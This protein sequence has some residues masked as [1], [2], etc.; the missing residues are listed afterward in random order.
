MRP[1]ILFPLFKPVTSLAGVGPRLGK[2]I[3]GLAGPHLADL[4]WHL[5]SGLIDRRFAPSVADTLPGVIATLTV[6]VDQHLKP[7]RPKL[8]YKVLCSDATGSLTL[9][10]FHAHEDYLRRQLPEGE[11][12]IISGRIEHF[13][14]EIQMA[15]PDYIARPEEA[16]S[17]R[18]VEPVYPLTTGLTLKKM[19]QAIEGALEQ[20]PELL[21]WQDPTFCARAGWPGWHAAL[22]AAHHPESLPELEPE[23]LP[24]RRLAYDELLANQ[25]ALAL[26]RLNMRRLGGRKIAGDGHLRHK[27][28]EALPFQ[29]THAQQRAG[30]EIAAD[31]AADTRMLRLLQG[32]VGSGK[33]VVA[34][35]AMLNAVECG[36]QAALMAPT[37]ILA[38][39][40][41][42]TIEPLAAALNLPV[43]LL[44]GREKGRKRQQILDALADGSTALV[45][46]THALFQEDVAF[47]DLGLAI[48]DEQHRFGVHQRLTLAAKGRAVDVLV[49][50]ATPIP[51]TLMLTAYG[52]MDVSR[53]DEKPPGRQPIKT[54]ALPNSRLEEVVN[55]LHRALADGAR[56]Y[57]VCPLVADSETT[58]AAA[59]EARFEHLKESLGPHV[60]LVHGRMKGAEKDQAMADFAEGRLSVLVATTVI[61]VGVDVPEATV[62]IIEHAERFGLA[63]LHQLRGR[64]GRGGRESSCL[65]LYAPP[66]SETARKRLEVLRETED[67]FR[68]AE[69]DLKLRGAGELMGTRQS[70]LPE[71]KLADLTVHGDLL[72]TARDDAQLII[73]KDPELTGPRGPALRVLLYLFERDAAV[74][75]LRG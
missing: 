55:G 13:G 17:L 48:I 5:P 15:H 28:F 40:H 63:Q 51:R 26:V 33:T 37:E 44:T 69:E 58:D 11:T 66:L 31:M 9:V 46:G 71:F 56:A 53:L 20:T 16:D 14:A 68:I 73:D 61:E 49:M 2:L 75:F 35:A 21:E 47:H 54:R 36:M 32:D 42:K 74:R 6:T 1:E 19:R 50:T 7:P 8:P 43:M 38:R 34:L 18:I 45:I 12:R 23:A 29:L 52:D 59:A 22:L 60:G 70:G 72:A 25:L 67:G 65:L 30:R 41:L 24:R 39:Q 27:L 3:E 57:W 62:M 4:L 10:F 64:I